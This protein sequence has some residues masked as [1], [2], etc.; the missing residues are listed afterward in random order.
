MILGRKEGEI[1][2]KCGSQLWR[3][4]VILIQ[5]QKDSSAHRITNS[6]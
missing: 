4:G 3:K 5:V 1:K 2:M 6:S